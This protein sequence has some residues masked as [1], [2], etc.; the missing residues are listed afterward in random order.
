MSTYLLTGVAGFIGSHTARAL[1][2]QGHAVVGIDELNDYYDVRLKDHRISALLG[3]PNTGLGEDAAR[4]QFLGKAET[5]ERFTFLHRDVVDGAAMAELFD[6]YSF[7][8]VINLAARAGVRYSVE[9]PEVYASTNVSGAVNLL[10][11][12]AKAGVKKYVLAS[13]SSL[14]AGAPTPFREDYDVNRPLSPYAA[15]KLGAEAMAAAFHHLHGIDVSV[16]RY[17]T[18][19]GPASR[20]DMSPLR[21]LKWIDEGTPITLYGDGSQSRDFTYID[22]IVAGTLAALGPVGYEVINLGGGNRPMSIREMITGFEDALGKSAIIDQQPFHAGDMTATQADISKAKRI[23]DWEP[24]IL[25]EEG[26]RRTV[27]WY[28]ANRNWLKDI[29]L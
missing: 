3:R 12:M 8:A 6:R 25:P 1:L 21:F 20:P 7:D 22:D 23:L 13:S 9:H 27:E 18:V 29:R 28:R 2:G 14:Y 4:S 17:F 15:S 11:A 26:F 16:L 24:A 19:Y 5:F 10:Q